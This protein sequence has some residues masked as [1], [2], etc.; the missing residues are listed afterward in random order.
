MPTAIMLDLET[1]GTRPGSVIVAIGACKFAGRGAG[2]TFYAR[3]DPASCER[4]GLRM[5]A[6]TVTW[7]LRQGEEA[8]KELTK[9]GE[10]LPRVL[11]R[12][13]RWVG[14]KTADVWGNGANFDNALLGAAYDAAGIPRPWHWMNDRCYRTAKAILPRV[15]ARGAERTHH[16]LAD[17][18]RQAE[19]L[20]AMFNQQ[21]R[22]KRC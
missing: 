11:R 6:E 20:L 9:R 1:L 12:F 22:A 15:P 4:V 8:R 5:D 7:W 2:D 18:V 16:A 14:D 10:P 19:H 21:G 13:A 17:A 3:V